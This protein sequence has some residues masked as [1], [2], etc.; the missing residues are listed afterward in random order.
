MVNVN[1]EA[2]HNYFGGAAINEV[3]AVVAIFR[4][5]E[6]AQLLP[7]SCVIAVPLTMARYSIMMQ[8]W[9]LEPAKRLSF[10]ELVQSL[11]TSLES[12]AG[13]TQLCDDQ[14]QGS[15]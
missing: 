1:I 15:E 9:E 10:S 4:I 8:C 7:L 3:H 11:S 14:G 13:Y 6:I 12:L 2:D 5:L